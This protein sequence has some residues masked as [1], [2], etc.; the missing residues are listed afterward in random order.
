[1]GLAER[2]PMPLLTL[3]ARIKGAAGVNAAIEVIG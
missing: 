1:M 2:L 3:D